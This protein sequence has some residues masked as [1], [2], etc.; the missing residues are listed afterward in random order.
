MPIVSSIIH[1]SSL[2]AHNFLGYNNFYGSI[3]LKHYSS[4]DFD[5]SL[6]KIS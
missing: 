4:V 2:L 5:I 1:Q 3:H 6:F